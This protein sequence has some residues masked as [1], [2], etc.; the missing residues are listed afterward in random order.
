M[1]VTMDCRKRL[2][3]I[4]ICPNPL[5]VPDYFEFTT[6]NPQKNETNLIYKSLLEKHQ[7]R[8][9]LFKAVD[10][11]LNLAR[12]A[13]SKK[14]NGESKECILLLGMQMKKK[15][16]KKILFQNQ[17]AIGPCEH[18]DM[19]INSNSKSRDTMKMKKVVLK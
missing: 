16:K 7:Y 9:S 2:A 13:E 10:D 6:K 18:T 17:Q 5:T 3:I 4:A 1:T 11:F 15:K 19:Y 12:K 14:W 8:F